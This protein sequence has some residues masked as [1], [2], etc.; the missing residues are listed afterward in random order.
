MGIGAHLTVVR[1]QS[2]QAQASGCRDVKQSGSCQVNK[3]G[4]TATVQHLA[5]T[6]FFFVD[7]GTFIFLPSICIL[8]DFLD[9]KEEACS[10]R[11][12]R[13]S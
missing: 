3:R 2:V 12:T 11:I 9:I 4:Q 13:H 10:A 1:K 6:C 7:C 8:S 5:F